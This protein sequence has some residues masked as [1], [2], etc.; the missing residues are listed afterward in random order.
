MVGQGT[1]AQAVLHC[2][3]E[4]LQIL[5]VQDNGAIILIIL[6]LGLMEWLVLPSGGQVPVTP[7]TAAP[8]AAPTTVAAVAVDAASASSTVTASVTA[9]AAADTAAAAATATATAAA[10]DTAAAAGTAAAAA[11]SHGGRRTRLRPLQHCHHI[12]HEHGGHVQ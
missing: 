2:Y 1:V 9:A 7:A 6:L 3:M 8:T 10:A 4:G 5:A 11:A 12:A